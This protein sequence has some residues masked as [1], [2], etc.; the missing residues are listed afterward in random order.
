VRLADQARQTH[1]PF[2]S[3]GHTFLRTLPLAQFIPV[4]EKA[5]KKQ[6]EKKQGN[7]DQT[8]DKCGDMIPNSRTASRGLALQ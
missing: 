1:A 7:S 6:D 5:E 2:G 8:G 3:F 4:E